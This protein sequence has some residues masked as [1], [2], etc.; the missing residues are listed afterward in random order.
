MFAEC[1]ARRFLRAQIFDQVRH[2]LMTFFRRTAGAISRHHTFANKT[3]SDTDSR[4]SH[5]AVRFAHRDRGHRGLGA[6][7]T[8]HFEMFVRRNGSVSKSRWRV[9]RRVM[10]F[11]VVRLVRDAEKLSKKAVRGGRADPAVLN[12]D[13]RLSRVR[14]CYTN[15]ST[16]LR[17]RA[18][19]D[20]NLRTRRR[21]F[22]E[23]RNVRT[24][25]TIRR[26]AP[27]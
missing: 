10:N 7:C 26:P 25:C 11:V 9:V 24:A 21:F 27:I 18:R 16:Y 1:P 13:C 20:V 8:V 5:N 12:F 14:A 17:L 15:Q 4:G 19:D 2:S 3:C 23:R 6:M 22:R